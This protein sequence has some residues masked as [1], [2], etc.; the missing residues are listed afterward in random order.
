MVTEL[1]ISADA[2]QAVPTSSIT[3]TDHWNSCPDCGCGV[4]E[5]HRHECD[6]ERCSVCGTQRVSCDG[7]KGHDPLK[8]AWTGAWPDTGPKPGRIP[9]TPG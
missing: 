5:P 8:S 6:V 1:N 2:P 3:S 7:C 4:G 9:A